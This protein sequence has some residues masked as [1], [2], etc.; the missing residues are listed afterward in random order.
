MKKFWNKR[1]GVIA[2]LVLVAVSPLM[3]QRPEAVSRSEADEVLVVITPHNETIRSEFTEAF[4]AYWQKK[5]G[6]K[7]YVDWR[8]PGGT[9]EIRLVLDSK[10]ANAKGGGVGIDVF[11]GSKASLGYPGFTPEKP[12]TIRTSIG[13]VCV[14]LN[15][16]FVIMWIL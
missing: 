2:A 13:W 7:V 5:T 11:F 10:F 15:L 9:S 3:L 12:I 1:I 14:C 4:N 6:K 16:V 8:T